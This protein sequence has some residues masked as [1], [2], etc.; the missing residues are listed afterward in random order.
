MGIKPLVS[1]I[2]PCFNG[3][4]FVGRMLD[5]ILAQTHA[6]IEMICVNDGSTDGTESVIKSYSDRFAA[7]GMT[8]K[9]LY[10][11]NQGQAA[12]V[13]NGLK[14]VTGEYLCWIDCDD[15]LTP[16]SAELRLAILENNSELGVCS[17]DLFIV[18]E[19][20]VT[21]VQKLN[22]ENCGHLNFQRNQF[23][24]TIAGLSSVECHAHMVRMSCFD[25]INPSR[26][27]SR[28]REGQN[29]QMLLPLYYH[30]PRGYID[31]PLGYY[32]VRGDSHYHS[33]RTREREIERQMNLLNM[34]K[35]TLVRLGLP[36]AEIRKLANISFFTRE[37]RRLSVNAD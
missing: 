14:H 18:G 7:K 1:V 20:D 27:I 9:Y 22:S 5:S 16:D 15:F 8:L 10:Q 28:C 37:I 36:D 2:S 12:A 17:S 13:N 3:E 25:K 24:L 21:K 33:K 31:K 26:E 4:S 23:V 34:L 32:V 29:Y 30:F 19:S 6:N 35:E 11:D